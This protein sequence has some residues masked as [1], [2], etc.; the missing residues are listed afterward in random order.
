MTVA[1]GGFGL[2]LT[3]AIIVTKTYFEK[4]R[5][6]ASSIAVT[7]VSIG[8]FVFPM[9]LIFLEDSFAL[10]GLFFTLAGIC[11]VICLCGVAMK[12]EVGE[13]RWRGYN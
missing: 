1:G 2:A 5:T 12:T 10:K 13:G 7:G 9:L 6:L 3:P 4:R 8:V 11:L